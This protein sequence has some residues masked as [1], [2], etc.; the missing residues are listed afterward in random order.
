[1]EK[2]FKL[3]CPAC[4]EHLQLLQTTDRCRYCFSGVKNNDVC[5]KCRRKKV[6]YKRAAATCSALGPAKTLFHYFKRGTNPELAQS[7]GALMTMQ[8]L[9]LQWP[10]PDVVV[11]LS[12]SWL[13]RL[14]VGHDPIVSLA[15]E[16]AKGF[17]K[18]LVC[19]QKRHPIADKRILLIT[20]ELVGENERLRQTATALQEHFPLEIYAL[21]F[22]RVDAED[23]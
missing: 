5:E 18:P 15:R 17:E 13:T 16:V 20:D 21:A 23:G 9:Q 22:L 2:L 19:N 4:L 14:H 8:Y 1:M 11:P 7:L 3:L 6:V 10:L 12:T